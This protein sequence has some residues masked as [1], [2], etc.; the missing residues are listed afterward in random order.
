MIRTRTLFRYFLRELLKAFLLTTIALTLLVTMGGGVANVFRNQGV[1][2]VR[3]AKI[4]ALLVPIAVTLVLPVAALF[5]ATLTYGRFSADN[6]INAC[7]AAGINVHALLVPAA[8]LSLAVTAF[9]FYS[10]NYMIPGL[11]AR[12]YEYGRQD[13]AS[14]ILS[15]LRR[16]RGVMFRNYVLYADEAG[17]L[18]PDQ[19]PPEA[20][21][22]RS[23]IV[24]RSVAFLEMADTTPIRC[25]TTERAVVELDLSG[26][27]PETRI[28]LQA[29]HSYDIARGQYLELTHQLM[30]P[31]TIPLPLDKKLRFETLPVLQRYAEAPEEI[32]E[33]NDRI[34]GIRARLMQ[35]FTYQEAIKAFD[36]EQGGRGVLTLVSADGT[37][38]IRAEQFT[39]SEEDQQPYLRNVVVL[40]RSS[41]GTRELRAPNATLRLVESL[42][43]DQ[44]RVQ[45]E[46]T[47]GVEIRPVPSRPNDRVVKRPT[48][49]L[50]YVP[51]QESA[52]T[53]LRELT[54]AQI[55]NP[56]VL[57]PLPAKV[58]KA[59][60][61][62]MDVRE[63]LRCE[64]RSVIH[65]RASYALSTVPVIVLGAV[66]GVVLRGGQV[67][68][69]FG[70]SCIPSL[71]VVV[72][73]ILGRNLADHPVTH[74]AGVVAMWAADLVL[75]AGT[76]AVMWKFM[77]R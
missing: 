39:A 23:Y 75:A 52:R 42:D 69:A 77:R 22:G 54:F 5:S 41:A 9:T 34:H 57:I 72:G 13:I 14:V 18:D 28:D 36:P 32:P 44:P 12:V 29:V 25:G 8:A 68:T 55:L 27:T 19:L 33:M 70:I 40:D 43:R 3:V 66:L 37:I 47:G 1:D 53:R 64:V 2:A 58:A 71:V 49:R 48:E 24:L 26:R 65:F 50:R 61:K 62:L 35:V 16:N 21:P 74:E 4:F 6:E 59:R 46:L 45:V 38:E 31:F 20:P 63:S 51:M 60:E 10:W 11:T 30:G 67:L 76:A 73:T 15:N 56:E 17:E 7:R